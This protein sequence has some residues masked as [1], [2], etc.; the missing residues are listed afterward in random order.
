MAFTPYLAF[1]GNAREAFT[2]YNEIWGGE[3]VLFTMADAPPDAGP[4]GADPNLVLHAALRLGD[5]YVMGV[6]DPTGGF[7]GNVNGMCANWNTP[8]AGEAKRVFD[9]LAECG[10]IQ[11]P[12]G[13]T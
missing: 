11:L 8:D 12:M 3:L 2:R 7:D 10:E 9:A 1:T 13:E 6:D 5:E 4:P